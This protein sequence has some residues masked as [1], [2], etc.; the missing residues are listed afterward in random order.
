M[1]SKV[2][3]TKLQS[4]LEILQEDRDEIFLK[5]NAEEERVEELCCIRHMDQR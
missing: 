3:L 5:L 4:E 2:Q 1:A